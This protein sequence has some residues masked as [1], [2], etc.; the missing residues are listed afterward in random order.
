MTFISSKDYTGG[1]DVLSYLLCYDCYVKY[2]YHAY[3]LGG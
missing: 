1:Y 2:L 3:I